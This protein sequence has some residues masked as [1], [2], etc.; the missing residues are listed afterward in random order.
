VIDDEPV[1]GSTPPSWFWALPGIDRI[2]AFSQGLLLTPPLARLQGMRVAHVEPGS[3]TW[4]MPAS[5]WLQGPT[6]VLEITAFIETALTGVTLTAAPPGIAVVPRTL[7]VNYF[8]PSRAQAG[9]C[10]RAGAW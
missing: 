7:G 1:R 9:N 2:R 5:A 3:G 10:S 6:G 8:R 4:R